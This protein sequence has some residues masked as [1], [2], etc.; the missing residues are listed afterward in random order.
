MDERYIVT[1]D[2]GT[3]KIAV[4]V[5]RISGQDTE[6]LYYKERP[7]AG[8]RYGAIFNPRKAAGALKSAIED[9]QQELNIKITQLVVGLPRSGVRQEVATGEIGRSTPGTCITQEEVDAVKNFALDSYPVK[10]KE[11][12]TIYGASAQSF[13]TDDMINCSEDDVVGMPSSKIEGNFK[14]FIGREI[15]VKNIDHMLNELGVARARLYFLPE[16]TAEAVLSSEEK[17]NGTALIEMGGGVSSVTIYQG[18]ILRY[19]GSIPFGGCNITEDIKYECGFTDTLAENIKLGFGACMPD[20]LLNMSDKILR[21]ND[22]ENGNYQDLPVKY[23]SEVITCRVREIVEALLFQIQ[24][25]GYADRLRGGVVLTG[26]CA[27]LVNCANLIKEMS[28]Y[29]VR[30]GFP[31][32]RSMIASDCPGIG[33]A[34]AAATV[35]M[36]LKAGKDVHLNCTGEYRAPRKPSPVTKIEDELHTMSGDSRETADSGKRKHTEESN[37][38]IIQER[39]FADEG[40]PEADKAPKGGNKHPKG[41]NADNG[42]RNSGLALR[43]FKKFTGMAEKIGIGDNFDNMM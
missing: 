26:G 15:A 14:V 22:A 13:S 24:D 5:A 32:L 3:S 19:Y 31:K 39:L 17:E 2:L 37:T 40:L 9:A 42:N 29:N 21:I 10:D 23:L 35:G 30:A 8:I 11:K 7:S 38:E 36:L 43:W 18:G 25:S 1:V 20:K 16:S 28:G 34:G 12:F 4:C 6:V 27:N 33:E 41:T